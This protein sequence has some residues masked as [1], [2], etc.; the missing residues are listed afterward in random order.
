MAEPD[1]GGASLLRRGVRVLA[2]V[3]I[4]LWRPMAGR[5]F[6]P[7][8]AIVHH[9]GRR[10]GRE[11]STPVQIRAT[12]DAFVIALPFGAATQW[13]RN[14]R[15]A[16]ECTLTWRGREHRAD[17]PEILGGREG[18]AAFRFWERPF[19]RVARIDRFVRLR[20]PD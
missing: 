3:T 1:L 20:R 5:R 15:D 8:W 10:S 11:Y 6:L 13:V 16:G 4:P 9:R 7:A 14:V 12:R 18:A 2:R 19:L 17:A